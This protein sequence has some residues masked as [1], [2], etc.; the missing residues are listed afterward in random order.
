MHH[1]EAIFTIVLGDMPPYPHNVALYLQCSFSTSYHL[2]H[3]FTQG[4]HCLL[5]TVYFDIFLL[6]SNHVVAHTCSCAVLSD[7]LNMAMNQGFM[8]DQI[9]ASHHVLVDKW[10]L[11]VKADYKPEMCLMT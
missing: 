9:I 11:T 1:L 8:Q 4:I 7:N 5:R 6:V 3:N 10:M 2:T